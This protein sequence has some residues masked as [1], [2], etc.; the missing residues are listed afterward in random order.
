MNNV[1]S[2]SENLRLSGVAILSGLAKLPSASCCLNLP[3]PKSS[4]TSSG[5]AAMSTGTHSL[6]IGLPS[7]SFWPPLRF[8]RYT[9]P[10]YGPST[11]TSPEPLSIG[12]SM[13]D[14]AM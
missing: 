11:F 9:A 13:R 1:R 6:S 10:E 7:L 8:C 12:P 2:V 3:P 4:L 5:T 14:I